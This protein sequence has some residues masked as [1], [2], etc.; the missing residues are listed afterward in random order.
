MIIIC[1]TLDP[2]PK[3]GVWRL[4]GNGASD[5]FSLNRPS[6]AAVVFL[7]NCCF[8]HKLFFFFPHWTLQWTLQANFFV[9]VFVSELSHIRWDTASRHDCCWQRLTCCFSSPGIKWQQTQVVSS[10]SSCFLCFYFPLVSSEV[11]SLS[12]NN[13]IVRI[14]VTDKWTLNISLC[15]NLMTLW[16]CLD[17]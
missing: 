13:L 8:C 11:L 7:L 1:F 9:F 16:L 4:W 2:E 3:G 14:N 15:W 17:L 10:Y 12:P 5:D 6:H